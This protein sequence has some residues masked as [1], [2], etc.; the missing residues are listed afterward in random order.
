[1]IKK[2]IKRAVY[3]YRATSETYV[4]ELRKKGVV[5]GD[6]TKFINPHK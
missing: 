5:I 6:G 2:Y 4:K 3:G 1:M